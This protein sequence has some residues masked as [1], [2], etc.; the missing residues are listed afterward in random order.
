MLAPH[1]TRRLQEYVNYRAR[2]LEIFTNNAQMML[3]SIE[4]IESS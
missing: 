2:T 4:C 3:Q 1:Q